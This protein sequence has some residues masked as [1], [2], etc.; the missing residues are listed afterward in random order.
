M[1]HKNNDYLMKKLLAFLLILHT[2]NLPMEQPCR[3]YQRAKEIDEQK[4]KTLSQENAHTLLRKLCA[5]RYENGPIENQEFIEIENL[6]KEGADLTLH[7]NI[8]RVAINTKSSR[9]IKLLT[10]YG[11][12]IDVQDKE[13]RTP[14]M[15]AAQLGN[16]EI[17]QTLLEGT[18]A[19]DL[20]AIRIQDK[21]PSYFGL[22]PSVVS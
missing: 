14:L 15:H 8:M 1:I 7:S 9:I 13:G 5:L 22:L 21:P 20:Y 10:N 12:P 3:A 18:P 6:L 17:V 2:V 11:A 16:F 4:R 19:P